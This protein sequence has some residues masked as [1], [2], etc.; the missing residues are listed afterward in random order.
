MVEEGATVR[1]RQE[2]IKLP[3]TSQMLVEVKVHES[4]VNQIKPGL[5]A[6]VTVDSMPERRFVGSVRRVAPLPDTQSRYMNPNL[7]VYS[8]EVVIEEPLPDIKPGVS[9]HAEVIITNLTRVISVPVQAITTLKGQQY[10]YLAG[11]S[12]PVKVD[13][14]F[15][16]DRFVEIRNGLAENQRI[17]LS[18]PI[19]GDIEDTGAADLSTAEVEAAKAQITKRGKHKDDAKGA[20]SRGTG[21]S[22][23]LPPSPKPDKSAAPKSE[24]PPKPSKNTGVLSSK[25]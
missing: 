4:F 19:S 10:A 7:K 2:L 1:Q 21:K 9:A 24:K 25:P 8:T 11:K 20:I 17:L 18:P 14:G 15:N 13:V 5:L 23:S 3:D 16:N 12:E 22:S 6:Y